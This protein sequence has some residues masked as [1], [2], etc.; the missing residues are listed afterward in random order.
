MRL[1]LHRLLILV[2][3]VALFSVLIAWSGIINI[4]ASSGHWRITG[5]V[6]HWA[7][8][9]SIRTYAPFEPDPPADLDSPANIR[10]AAG[11]Y[12]A[13]CAFC[14]GSPLA[15]SRVLAANMTPAPP[16]LED[17]AAK[18][19]ERELAR[20]VRHGVKYTGMPSWIAPQRDDEVWSMVA[21]LRALPDMPGEEYRRLA[22]GPALA[23]DPALE[24]CI[25]CHGI[26]GGSSSGAFSILAGQSEAY[27]AETLRAYS[28]GTRPSGF[29][30]FAID[31]IAEP[32]LQRLARYY[33]D[34]P[35]LSDRS[36]PDDTQGGRIA[37]HG[38][39]EKDIPACESCHGSSA[40]RNPAY[41]RLAGQDAAYIA[42]QLTRMK[43]DEPLNAQARV[44][45]RIA[46]RLPEEAIAAVA[47]FYAQQGTGTLT[48][49]AAP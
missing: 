1:T 9:N 17:S 45:H 35:G 42:T 44:M 40:K 15:A 2:A 23:E 29:M 38:L 25:R 36:A 39:P 27:L 4:G 48:P 3:G 26:D 41:P 16:G 24:R 31:G 33:A 11:H 20:I 10:R 49:P 12:E 22:F 32:E 19:N 21:F 7:M 5:W 14:H 18:W 43:K 13:A 46:Q 37:F 30:Q 6:L 8:Q 47:A 28:K 34:L